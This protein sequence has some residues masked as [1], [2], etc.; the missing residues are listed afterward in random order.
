MNIVS[1]LS[2]KKGGLLIVLLLAAAI[3]LTVIMSQKQ[4]ETRQY[5][6]PVPG[7]TPPCFVPPQILAQ[8]GLP[9]FPSRGYGDVDGDGMITSVDALK[10]LR[11]VSGVESF[12][13]QQIELADVNG[14]PNV[15]SSKSDVSSV[16]ALMI[17]RYVARLPL[18]D[19]RISFTVCSKITPTPALIPPWSA[20]PKPT[21]YYPT[22]T[23]YPYP[24]PSPVYR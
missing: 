8:L 15:L 22:P 11:F 20:T 3:P 10:I 4:Q 16:D 12:S 21:N 18:P 14:A 9:K 1:F 24:T 6:A 5:A 7:S 13:G 17:L 19:G 2:S 23:K